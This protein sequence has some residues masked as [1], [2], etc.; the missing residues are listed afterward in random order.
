[1]IDNTVKVINKYAA[2]GLIV[3]KVMADNEFKLTTDAVAPAFVN[4]AVMGEHVGDIEVFL[5]I[6]QEHALCINHALPYELC[7]P[8]VMTVGL[9][10]Y[11]MAMKNA[12]PAKVG[13]S[14]TI[15]S[16]TI[17]NGRWPLGA[18]KLTLPFGACLHLNVDTNNPTSTMKQC[19]VPFI[20][21][22]SSDNT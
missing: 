3:H 7:W 6:L 1:M 13:I 21:L 12:F 19:T 8:R 22:G 16:A 15:S 17:V 14:T 4:L 9:M 2:S 5:R 10:E 20:Y 18:S 11:I